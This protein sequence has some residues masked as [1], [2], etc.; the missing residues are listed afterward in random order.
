MIPTGIVTPMMIFLYSCEPFDF[1]ATYGVGLP[2][3]FSI[4]LMLFPNAIVETVSDVVLGNVDPEGSTVY[5]V[6]VVL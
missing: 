4:D 1:F 6:L 3:I 5:S 2:V